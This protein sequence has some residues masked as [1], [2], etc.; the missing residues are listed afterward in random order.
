MGDDAAK[1]FSLGATSTGAGPG[2]DGEPTPFSFRADRSRVRAA[3]SLDHVAASIAAGWPCII[4]ASFASLGLGLSRSIFMQLA[5]DPKNAVIFTSRAAVPADSVAAQLVP[6]GKAASPLSLTFTTTSTVPLV[7][8]ELAAWKEAR[9]EERSRAARVVA[10]ARARMREADELSAATAAA[11]AAAAEAAAAAAAALATAS[12]FT[13]EA[14]AMEVDAAAAAAAS[15]NVYLEDDSEAIMSIEDIDDALHGTVS[16]VGGAGSLRAL[17]WRAGGPTSRFPTFSRDAPRDAL[18]ANTDYGLQVDPAAFMDLE[19]TGDGSPTAALSS[20]AESAGQGPAALTPF[21]PQLSEPLATKRVRSTLTM[22]VQCRVAMHAL[23]GCTVG[24][25]LV[26]V[27]EAAMPLRLIV[28]A[29][30]ASPNTPAAEAASALARAVVDARV[31]SANAVSI[32]DASCNEP[33]DVSSHV[34]ELK[35]RVLHAAAASDLDKHTLALAPPLLRVGDTHSLAYVETQILAVARSTEEGSEMSSSELFLAAAEGDE[36][37][38]PLIIRAGG[39]LRLSN[40]R[41]RLRKAG[42]IA[43]VIE[44][45]L[46]TR[47]GVIVRRFAGAGGALNVE[48]PPVPELFRVREIVAEEHV[49]VA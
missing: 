32:L 9:E 20:T 3:A 22:R 13:T 35:L 8:A 29:G 36:G 47:G 31:L 27:L 12:V 41:Q 44:G 14:V 43:E 42:I 40:L 11:T 39:P 48:G 19:G 34:S 37:H 15:R 4:L 33:L 24:E 16:S 21:A 25:S 46:I 5:A 17:A 10:V 26:H 18:F 49:F 7:G 38:L 6:I 28:L 1:A 30:C 45:A 2:S 23:D